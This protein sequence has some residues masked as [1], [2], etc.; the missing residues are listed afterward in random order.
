[1]GYSSAAAS[2]WVER[3]RYL[4]AADVPSAPSDATH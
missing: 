1:V 2:E 3:I 4:G